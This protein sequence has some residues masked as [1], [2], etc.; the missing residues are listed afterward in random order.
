MY[1]KALEMKGFKSFIDDIRL[2]FSRGVTSIVGPNGCGKSN[3]YDA[4]RWVLGEQ[5]PK[6]LRG[7]KMEDI[8]FNGTQEKK[9]HGLAEV[10]LVMG[11]LRGELPA[12]WGNFDEIRI[13]RRLFRSGES[14]YLIN[15]IPCRLKDIVDLFL[16]TG[17]STHAFSLIEQG[18]IGSIIN[19][20]PENRRCLIEE[21]A[22]IIKYKH[23]KEIALRKLEHS[24]QNLVR[25][26][27]IISE[28]RRQVNSLK[29]QAKKAERYKEYQKRIQGLELTIFSG[30]YSYL[31]K[32]LET[33]NGEFEKTSGEETELSAKN[34]T[35]E[36]KIENLK[37]EIVES[38][39][40]LSE[41]KGKAFD[42]A[43]EINRIENRIERLKEQI[44]DIKTEK[45]RDGKEIVFLEEKLKELDQEVVNYKREEEQYT[46]EIGSE[47]GRIAE[48]KRGLD[49]LEEK[50][51]Q[52]MNQLNEKK[53]LHVELISQ[54]SQDKNQVS[55]L[56]NKWEN[57][58]YSEK[59]LEEERADDLK[60]RQDLEEGLETGKKESLLLKEKLSETERDR[61]SVRERLA[62]AEERDRSL[63]NSMIEIQNNLAGKSSRLKSLE[64][65]ES[66]L[67]GY[68]QGVRYLLKAQNGSSHIE[69]IH[70]VVA[71]LLETSSEYEVALTAVLGEKLQSLVV[72]DHKNI[73]KAITCLK[74]NEK[75]R[76]TFIPKKPKICAN[77]NSI[78]LNGESGVVGKALDLIKYKEGFKDVLEFL[79]GDVVVVKD[80][81][82]A[83]ELYTEEKLPFT[84]VTLGG[85]V[86]E[87]SGVTIGG[88]LKNS[89]NLQLLK[90]N[91]VM[92][93]LRSEIDLLNRQLEEKKHLRSEI[94]EEISTL[95]VEW[96][97]LDATRIDLEKES[98]EL[99]K[100]LQHLE[101]E[102]TRIKKRIDL[103]DFERNQLGKE[104]QEIRKKIEEIENRLTSLTEKEEA[105][106]SEINQIQESIARFNQDRETIKNA[107]SEMTVTLTSLMGKQENSLLKLQQINQRKD[108]IEGRIEDLKEDSLRKESR[109]TENIESINEMESSLKELFDNKAVIEESVR[110]KE[111]VFA[112]KREGLTI[113]ENETKRLRG[114]I[115][116][117]KG[118][119][120]E[121]DI[122]RTE[123]NT[124]MNN[125]RERITIDYGCELQDVLEKYQEDFPSDEKEQE[126]NELK[127]K[128]SGFGDVNLMAIEEYKSLEERYSFLSEQRNDLVQSIESLHSV[129]DRIN[130]T[131][132]QLFKK[133]FD[134][135]NAGF[136]DIYPRLFE[137]GKGE[138]VL[139]DENNL[140]ETGI[141]MMVQPSGKRLQSITL[142]SAGEKALTAVAMLFAIFLVK[143]SPF[144]L[145]DE[146]DAPLDESNIERFSRILRE[147]SERTQFIVI[148][149]NKRTMSFAD[150]LYG[151]TMEEEGV[152]TV[153]SLKL[154]ENNH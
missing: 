44:E 7:K 57:I 19:S 100:D 6:L 23:K 78:S 102:Y 25:L 21:A 45:E 152:S 134:A 110:S 98:L 112:E 27:D 146:V 147:L 119:V 65:L 125:I 132:K 50:I 74:S 53:A 63:E 150:V 103:F 128:L 139:T 133:T 92:K 129:I 60:R 138:L 93:E 33:W 11:D 12:E 48:K 1:F 154:N 77:M 49:V 16:D 58:Q 62:K 101:E 55:S 75:G 59:R 13:S 91:R 106:E 40:G 35:L 124:K 79:L 151:V 122:K 18:Q 42:V 105:G 24:N 34:S 121:I 71:D 140:L 83:L 32:E 95:E 82:T 51:N 141:D 4:I 20:K 68:E 38:E 80:F 111:Q 118:R 123:L 116:E 8:I 46:E 120:S 17:V 66:S 149:H 127:E 29:R 22:G 84:L 14:E 145:L 142:L 137:G 9:P 114:T 69:G 109:E 86:L 81:P 67:E 113:L 5:S 117:L 2:E 153:V 56:T 15:K 31:K 10:S 136:Q 130:R 144:C 148:T 126:L 88:N 72:E 39:K 89:T 30:K 26:E 94:E 96:E 135:V 143:P 41:E 43:G 47:Q 70:G 131:T 54:I 3:I 87:P 107:L 52:V 64:E 85:D 99:G 28:I 90:K 104:G 61:E 73:E 36:N 115:D 37:L 76:G 108:D 97:G